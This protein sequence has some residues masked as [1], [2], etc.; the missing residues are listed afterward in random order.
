MKKFNRLWFYLALTLLA[1]NLAACGSAPTVRDSKVMVANA[2]KTKS[3][4]LIYRDVEMKVTS[5]TGT[6]YHASTDNNGFDGFGKLVANQS[7]TAFAKFGVAPISSRVLERNTRLSID[8]IPRGAGDVILPV[9]VITPMSGKLNANVH[10]ATASYVF[11]A[12]LID[13]ASKRTIWTASIDT[14][15]WQGSDVILRQ[16]DGKTYNDA[17]ALQL[18]NALANQMKQDGII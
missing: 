10:A 4:Q 2:E 6:L 8:A 14:S 12:A 13:F 15:T 16:V 1:L 3:L 7:E 17:Y 5:T 11:A 9:L 18:L